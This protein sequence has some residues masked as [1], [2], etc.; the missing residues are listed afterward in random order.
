MVEAKTGTDEHLT[1]TDE[2]QTVAYPSAVRRTLCLGDAFPTVMI[3]LTTDRAEPANAKAVAISYLELAIAF[4]RALSVVRVADD[5]KTL[6]KLV[7]THLATF[8]VFPETNVRD[9]LRLSDADEPPSYWL[10]SHLSSLTNF[11]HLVPEETDR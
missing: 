3:Y 5:V 2:M 6:Y 11:L 4:A 10:V 7:I 1:S 9:L 8:A